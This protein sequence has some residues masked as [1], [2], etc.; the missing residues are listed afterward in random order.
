MDPERGSAVRPGADDNA[1]GTAALLE[2]ARRL[3]ERPARRSVLIAAFDAEEIGLLGSAELLTHP[4]IDR[5]SIALM[6][7][8]DMVGRLRNDRLYVEVH[9]PRALTAL[10]D[11][12]TRAFN[13][14]PTPTKE[15]SGRSDH[16]TFV[17]WHIPAVALFTGFHEDYHR[18]G[19]VAMRVD[20]AGIRRVVDVAERIV[21]T[22]ADS[23]AAAGSGRW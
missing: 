9:G 2:L 17:D 6:V 13:L 16:S 14:R 23:E 1:S 7:N 8:L 11:S 19:D 18:T 22:T 4:P 21:R 3:A 12:S 10:V 20:F 5:R 15:T